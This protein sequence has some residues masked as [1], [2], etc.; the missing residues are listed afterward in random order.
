MADKRTY[1]DRAAYLIRAVAKRR[2]VLKQKAVDY[3]GGACQFCGY[4]RCSNA[5]EFHHKDPSQKDFGISAK[6]YTRSWKKVQQEL[7]KCVLVCSNCH[8]EIH[9][10][11]KQL[12][13]ATMK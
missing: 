3:M 12:S 4:A 6:G 10:G 2:Q 7:D 8:Q 5:L 1:K 9:A 11:I 13:S